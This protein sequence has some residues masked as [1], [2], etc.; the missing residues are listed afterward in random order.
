MKIGYACINLSLPRSCSKTFRL[1]SFSKQKFLEAAKNNLDGLME[2]LKWNKLHDIYFF[3]ISSGLIPYA[4]HPVCKINWQQI[5]KKDFV[6]I[7]RHIRA[8][9]MRISMHPDHFTVLNSPRREIVKKSVKTLE[10]HSDI[11]DLLGLDDSNKMQ[12]HAGGV[13]GDKIKSKA[14]FIINYKKLPVK[15]K[16]RLVLEN[17]DRLFNL[18]DCLDISR[19]T[20]M[21]VLLDVFHHSLLNKGESIR[22]AAGAAFRTWK[23]KDGILMVDFSSQAKGK[24]KGAHSDYVNKRSFKN[25]LTAVQNVN[26]DVML[27]AKKKD[28]AV[29]KLKQ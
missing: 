24:R 16:R 6:E 1:A 14:R 23:K 3:R 17:D 9:K 12:I 8:N 11:F 7:G 27:E 21:P 28:L 5:F 29:L 25:F 4:D 10:Y 20:G 2:I 15:I 18:K 19:R 13:Y 26:K 22:Q